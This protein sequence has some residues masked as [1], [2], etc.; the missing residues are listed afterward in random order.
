M[1][2][3]FVLNK[4]N[5]ALSYSLILLFLFRLQ[6]ISLRTPTKS[7]HFIW[8][9]Q[10][11]IKS[12]VWSEQT[13][14]DFPFTNLGIRK[15]GRPFYG[16]PAQWYYFKSSNYLF[17]IK[18][19]KLGFIHLYSCNRIL[20]ITLF[21]HLSYQLESWFIKYSLIALFIDTSPFLKIPSPLSFK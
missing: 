18:F 4:N 9:Y 13:I 11:V 14:N 8:T 5:Y 17:V 2:F 16:F 21:L 7:L 1:F 6:G 15:A 20:W 12:W 10:E 3:L 19:Y